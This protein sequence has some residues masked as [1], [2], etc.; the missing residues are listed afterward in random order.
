MNIKNVLFLTV[1]FIFALVFTF[2]CS[3][4]DD[5]SGNSSNQDGQ[6][7]YLS[8]EIE[9]CALIGTDAHCYVSSVEEC[10][11]HD[12]SIKTLGWCNANVGSSNTY[13][14]D[15]EEEGSCLLGEAGNCYD[16]YTQSECDYYG[17]I[18]DKNSCSNKP[19][20]PSTDEP[21]PSSTDDTEGYC[22]LDGICYR[23]I[24]KPRAVCNSAGGT[25]SKSFC[26]SP[27]LPGDGQYC[28]G[29][30]D[31]EAYCNLIGT[32][33][34]CLFFDTDDCTEYGGTVKTFDWCDANVGFLNIYGCIN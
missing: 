4:P 16:G 2:S 27:S 30:Y 1:N 9:E 32:D 19:A 3:T 29:H 18:F 13:G 28:Y 33:Y 21:P 10:T 24:E 8:Y 7:C 14:C 25:F 23:G 11:T 20:S 22:L 15:K 6:Y 17:G 31:E 5:N 12:G 26:P 34:S